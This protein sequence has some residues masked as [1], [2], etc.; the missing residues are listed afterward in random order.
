M[1]LY[2]LEVHL[3]VSTPEKRA[4]SVARVDQIVKD[5][6]SPNARLVAGPWGSL[7][8]PTIWAVFDNPDPLKSLP[9]LMTMYN[10]GLITDTRLRPIATWAEVKA[11]AE[12]AQ[13]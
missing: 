10:A 11:A 8:N 6:G 3:D 1:A 5:G 4:Q 9:N 12:K 2:L 13:G 7:E